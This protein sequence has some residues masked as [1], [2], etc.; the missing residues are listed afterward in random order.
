MLKRAFRIWR[1]VWTAFAFAVLGVGGFLL[2]LIVIPAITLFTHDQHKRDRRAQIIIRESF[3]FYLA[4]LRVLGVLR[5]DVVGA[6]KLSACRGKLIVANHPTLID[7]VLLVALL[8]GAKCV[9]KYQLF[10]NPL[11]RRLVREAGY[12]PDDFEP[13]QLMEKCRAALA[14]GNNLIIFPE[15]TRSVP[16]KPLRFKRL[17]AHIATLTEVN[18]QPITITCEPVTLIKGEPFYRIPD[19]RPRFRIE[20]AEEVETNR[21][22]DLSSESRARGVRKLVSYLESEY[23]RRLRHA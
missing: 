7:I 11:L 2:A 23:G 19:S 8:P 1:L 10:R 15:G 21:I 4:M 12:I 13:A 5:L 18:L 17:F 20:V 14:D 6:E 3:R 22:V 16:G 9:V